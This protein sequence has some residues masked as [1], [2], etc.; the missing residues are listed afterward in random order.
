VEDLR[1]AAPPMPPPVG[2]NRHTWSVATVTA[3]QRSGPAIRAALAEHG[4]S[5]QLEQFENEMRAALTRAADEF[6]VV[7]VDAVLGRWHALAMMAA[8]P[9]TDDE[10]AQVARAR[11]GDLAGFRARDEHGNW[12]TR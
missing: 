10:Q 7:G 12:I 9:L 1:H 4:V 6:D 5:G 3:V 11:A 2:V 8:N